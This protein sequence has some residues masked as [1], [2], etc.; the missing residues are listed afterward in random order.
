MSQRI[1]GVLAAITTPFDA[2]T[3]DVAPVHLRRNV[4][5]LIA[6]GLDGIVVA[7]STGEAATL[8]VD[9]H[10]RLVGCVRDALP[11]GRWLVAGAGAEATRQ[12]IALSRAAAE[13][14]ADVVLVRPPAYFAA[15]TSEASLLEYYRAVA[16]ASPVPV[17]VYN[18]PKHTH[19]PL[20]PG[21]LQQV[22]AHPNIAGVKDSSGDA[23]TLAAYRAAV[24]HGSVLVGPG[25]LL[26]SAL[27][28]GCDGGILAV[29]CYAA[30]LC[31]DVVAAFRAGDRE[32]AGA[33]QARLMPLD[34][35]IAGRLGP[36]G[37]KVAM[38][39]VG[40]YGGPCRAPLA[41]APAAERE[42][43]ARLLAA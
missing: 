37:V 12:A 1:T 42:R 43:V 39:V 6:A 30:T 23:R 10:R 32:R 35:E 2:V 33:L 19:L 24:P 20:A 14:G 5:S 13:E 17:L 28:M 34:M 27:E 26:Y 22:V 9:E 31:V 8:D 18:I 25:T 21:L 16:D 41:S 29:A 3:G 4:A 36:A 38:D 7:G 40:L 11:D 15:A